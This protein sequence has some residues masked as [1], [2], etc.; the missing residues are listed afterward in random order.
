VRRLKS[1]I[2]G[3]SLF[4]LSLYVPVVLMTYFPQWYIFNCKLHQQCKYIG[5]T[6][7]L[8]HIDELTDFFL[9]KKNLPVEWT[10]KEQLHLAEVRRIVDVLAI[11]AVIGIILFIISFN[12]FK[13]ANFALIN[14]LIILSMLLVVPFFRTF[15]IKIFHPLLFN[16]KRWW[17]NHLDR[18]FYIMPESFFKHSIIFMIAFSFALNLL[19]WLYFKK[20][21]KLDKK[22]MRLHNPGLS[23]HQY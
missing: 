10:V 12:R 16:N 14:F 7:A 13:I 11:T 19:V 5:Y 20:Y 1:I 8:K 2:L 21:S 4:Y 15:W 22:K 3:L 6:T 18:S 17:T 9:H 23:A